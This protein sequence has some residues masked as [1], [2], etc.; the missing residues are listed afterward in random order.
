VLPLLDGESCP[1]LHVS[2]MEMMRLDLNA[3]NDAGAAA[4]EQGAAGG[5]GGGGG[6]VAD[7]GPGAVATAKGGGGGHPS[8]K[9]AKGRLADEGGDIGGSPDS[10]SNDLMGNSLASY[11]SQL[12]EKVGAAEGGVGGAGGASGDKRADKKK[13]KKCKKVPKNKH[14]KHKKEPLAE[15]YPMALPEVSL[16]KTPSPFA[17]FAAVRA[18]CLE[19]RQRQ[20]AILQLRTS[21]AWKEAEDHSLVANSNA[22]GGQDEAGHPPLSELPK[23]VGIGL[24]GVLEIIRES[25][26]SF[27]AVCSRALGALLNILQGLRPE[28]L[29]REP[30]SVMEPMFL[31]L[32]ELAA[33]HDASTDLDDHSAS[34]AELRSLACAC[35]LSFVVALGDTGKLIKASTTLIMAPGADHDSIVMPGIM[36][37]LQR[38]VTSVMLGKTEHPTFLS[39]GVP[40]AAVLDSFSLDMTDH[41]DLVGDV[42]CVASDGSYLYVITD[43]GECVRVGSGYGGTV[44][45]RTYARRDDF[46]RGPGWLGCAGGQLFYH[47][48]STS[49]ADEKRARF[50][51]CRVNQDQLVVEDVYRL[52]DSHAAALASGATPYAMVSDGENVGVVTAATSGSREDFI[53]RFLSLGGTGDGLT[54]VDETPLKLACKSV[55]LFGNSPIDISGCGGGGS[56]SG[57]MALAATSSG[58]T[59]DF[60]C[61]DE[62]VQVVAGKEFAL[63]LSNQGKIYFQGKLLRNTSS[64]PTQAKEFVRL[65]VFV[66]LRP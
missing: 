31:T 7:G 13:C 48:F 58:A 63:M 18:T 5:G 27:P 45:G 10:V 3:S 61:D 2:Y 41:S 54:C 30:P 6:G 53:V 59:I 37:S 20:A 38:S 35:L 25:H 1:R 40:R 47:G 50:E 29:A 16:P 49:P 55:E 46:P 9:R 64:L 12:F 17:V 28:E 4:N 14:D 51:V 43:A 34:E 36:V 42:Q 57:K 44:K 23:I 62:P 19:S 52:K 26:R 22:A 8:S 65:A 21:Q 15:L 60:G 33:P 66:S 32:L 11:F 56:K 39:H 24:Q